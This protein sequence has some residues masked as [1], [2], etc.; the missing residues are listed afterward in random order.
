[1]SEGRRVACSSLMESLV[2]FCGGSLFVCRAAEKVEYVR[3]QTDIR[4]CPQPL[5]YLLFLDEF[6]KVMFRVLW[7]CDNDVRI[8]NR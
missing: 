2:L 6:S 5:L 4:V 3:V 7:C 8:D 1:M